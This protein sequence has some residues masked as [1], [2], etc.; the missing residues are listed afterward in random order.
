MYPW[1]N[2][3]V[4]EDSWHRHWK[5]YIEQIKFLQSNGMRVNLIILGKNGF[6]VPMAAKDSPSPYALENWRDPD[7]K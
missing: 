5:E 1:L 2:F 4:A 3:E 6:A 7:E